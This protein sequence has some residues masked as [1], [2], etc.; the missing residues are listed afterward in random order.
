MQ[1]R[2]DAQHLGRARRRRF[3]IVKALH[4]S[5]MRHN[6]VKLAEQVQ[7]TAELSNTIRALF[8]IYNA[9]ILLISKD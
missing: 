3:A 9:G 8:S 6:L 7:I 1:Q 4:K 2:R 5:E